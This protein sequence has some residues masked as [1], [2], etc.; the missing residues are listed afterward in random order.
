[1]K[2]VQESRVIPATYGTESFFSNNAF[3]FVNEDGVKQ[4]GRYK[5]PPVAG[6]RNLSDAEAKTKSAN[7]LVEDLGR[8]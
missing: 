7:F 1:L 2:F 8:V 3:I 4:A 5:I 6:Q